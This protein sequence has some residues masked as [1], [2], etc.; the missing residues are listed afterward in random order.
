MKKFKTIGVITALEEKIND[1]DRRHKRTNEDRKMR[2]QRL[3]TLEED[4][5]IFN[6]KLTLLARRDVLLSEL[7]DLQ[8]R[9]E[10]G[11]T[12]EEE[13]RENEMFKYG[14]R[15]LIKYSDGIPSLV[16]GCKI[17]MV[18][19][20]PCLIEG[21]YRGLSLEDYRDLATKWMIDRKKREE[22]RFREQLQK[23]KAEGLP[24]P[25]RK[26]SSIKTIDRASLPPFPSGCV[27]HLEDTSKTANK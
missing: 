16:D 13:I 2:G 24:Q 6:E 23:A 15:L 9:L 8:E 1:C 17:E 21:P 25:R 7:A 19:D 12:K 18:E 27:N 4:T 22:Q 11:A 5:A 26:V 14:L 10:I 3:L 20:V